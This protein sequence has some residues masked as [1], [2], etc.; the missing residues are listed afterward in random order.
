MIEYDGTGYHGWQRQQNAPSIQQSI[1]EVIEKVVGHQVELIGAGRTDAGVH[2]LGQTANFHTSSN[3][4][5]DK[6]PLAFNS[7]LPDDIVIKNTETVPEDFHARYQAKGKRYRYIIRNAKFPSAL[8]RNREYFCHYPL[9]IPL[10][11]KAI[12]L[13][14]G[15]HDFKG[16]AAAGSSAKDTVR[17]IY[18]AQ[19]KQEGENLVID[20]YGNGFLYNMVRI[21][22]GTLVDV[23]RGK[24][25][26][27][28]IEKLI[29]EGDRKLGG[30]TAPPQGL[31]LVEVLY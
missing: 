8:M 19:I 23:G 6:M 4:V 24:L 28:N 17:T 18:D 29:S 1:E 21:M 3:I 11:Q 2:A 25:P 13:F 27:E 16:L 14:V 31:Y 30:I 5:I 22:V 10:M 26:I 9:D 12:K 7:M 15:M 20:F